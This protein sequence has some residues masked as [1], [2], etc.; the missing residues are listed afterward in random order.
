M[1]PLSHTT[2]LADVPRLSH[3]TSLLAQLYFWSKTKKQYVCHHC[4]HRPGSPLPIDSPRG[5]VGLEASGRD[6]DVT[7]YDETVDDEDAALLKDDEA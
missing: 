6:S 1:I 4:G 5:I 7:C 2:V 3:S